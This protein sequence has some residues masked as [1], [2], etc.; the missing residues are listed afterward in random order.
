M[1]RYYFPAGFET[2]Y[3]TAQALF[4]TNRAAQSA[5]KSSVASERSDLAT[6]RPALAL[7][8]TTNVLTIALKYVGDESKA[9]VYF[10][11]SIL[12]AA[13]R[14]SDRKVTSEIDPGGIQNIFDNIIKGD[15]SLKIKNT[16]E[17]NLLFGFMPAPDE[18][19]PDTGHLVTP[20]QTITLQAA[21]L[22]WTS[23]IK[24]LNATNQQDQ[25]GEY[26]VEK[27]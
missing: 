10:D 21:E 13:F 4:V 23:V 7:Q 11:Q 16:G 12:D 15:L 24:F 3:F 19:V 9:D 18:A 22:G 14:A 20:G 17:V 25:A 1:E 27:V 6:T 8:L 2:D 5:A 26:S